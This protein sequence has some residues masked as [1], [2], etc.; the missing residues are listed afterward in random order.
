[1]S[2]SVE[3]GRESSRFFQKSIFQQTMNNFISQTMDNRTAGADTELAKSATNFNSFAAAARHNKLSCCTMNARGPK[4]ELNDT[5]EGSK[6]T[7]STSVVPNIILAQSV[8]GSVKPSQK[9]LLSPEF[10]GNIENIEPTSTEEKRITHESQK[11]NIKS[12][13][14]RDQPSS[15]QMRNIPEGSSNFMQT[16]NSKNKERNLIPDEISK[17]TSKLSSVNDIANIEDSQL[18]Y[19][20]TPV[21]EQSGSHRNLLGLHHN[22]YDKYKNS[23]FEVNVFNINHIGEQVLEQE[24]YY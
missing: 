21:N 7:F 24:F 10:T 19:N 5:K 12:A 20:V 23:K 14:G 11:T 9:M 13:L 2:S 8:R 4:E 1:M 16:T 3:L 6:N 22:T 18:H 15:E 17:T